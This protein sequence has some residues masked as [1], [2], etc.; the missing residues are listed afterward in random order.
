MKRI[1]DVKASGKRMH[2]IAKSRGRTLTSIADELE[3]D[4][5]DMFKWFYGHHMPSA[6]NLYNL[7]KVLD[8]DMEV[9]I[10]ERR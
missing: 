10:V 9:L 1:I 2:E 8:V 3:M 5:T 7:A 4:Y 6:Q